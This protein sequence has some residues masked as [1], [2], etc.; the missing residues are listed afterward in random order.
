MPAEMRDISSQISR[1]QS[2]RISDQNLRPRASHTISFCF[3]LS[4]GIEIEHLDVM[5]RKK[6]G[7]RPK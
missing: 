4:D 7:L 5:N 3:W 6:I 1:P 2:L